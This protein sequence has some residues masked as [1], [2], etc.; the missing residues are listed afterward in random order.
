VID[1]RYH[2]VSIV[3]VFLALAVGIVLGTYTIN[4]EVLKNIKH[5]VS[6]LRHTNDGLRSRIRTLEGQQG[7]DRAFVS[8]LDPLVVQDRLAKQRVTLVLAPGASNGVAGDVKDMV[9]AAGATVTSTV[10]INKTWVDPTQMSLLN[11]LAGRLAEPGISLPA[12]SAYERAGLVLSEALLR[13]PSQT[14]TATVTSLTTAD[15][16][17]LAGFKTAHFVS[18]TPQDPDPAT[19]AV[20]VTPDAPGQPTVQDR[21]A[22]TAISALARELDSAGGGTVVVGSPASANSGGVIAAV[23]ADSTTRKIVSTVDDAD[24]ES[25]R[26]RL[27][28]ALEAEL[29]D[30]SGQYGVGPGA[31][32]PAPSPAPSPSP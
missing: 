17:A 12:G 13:H 1:F 25:G 20:L 9:T 22:A 31:T 11:D 32:A 6:S 23:R 5:Q 30:S 14:S 27:V 2:I 21:N 15:T 18:M 19:L 3:A 29:R 8:A 4:G 10:H 7:K 16:T 24:T 28:L 26:I